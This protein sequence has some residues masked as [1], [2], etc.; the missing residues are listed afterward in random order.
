LSQGKTIGLFQLGGSGMTRYLKELAPTNIFDIMAMVALYRPGPI[1]SIP[2]Y[3]RR[4]HNPKLIHYTDPKMKEIL[5]MSNGIITYQDDVLLIAIN[6]AGYTWEEADKLRKAMGKKIPKEMAAQ[7]EKFLEGCSKNSGYVKEAAL[8]LWTLIEPFAAYGFNKSHAASYA[9]VAYQT[10]FMKANFPVEFMAAVL[11]AE[12]GDAETIADVVEECKSMGIEI[13]PPSANDSLSNFTVIDDQH[14]R[15]GLNAIK[16]LGSDT[17]A[18]IIAQRKTGGKFQNLEDFITRTQTRNFNKKS[19]E[20]LVKSGAMDSFGER[21]KLLANTEVVLEFA[22]SIHRDLTSSQVSLFGVNQIAQN[23]L[24]LREVEPATKK[25]LISWEK[26][27]LGLYVSAHPLDDYVGLLEKMAKP[28]KQVIEQKIPLATI[29]GIITKVQKILTKKGELMAFITVED[30]TNSIE[31]LVFPSLF[32]KV[33]DII[34]EEKIILI[35]GKLSSK[36]GELKLLADDIKEL[37]SPATSPTPTAPPAV[38]IKIPE[39]ATDEIFIELKR[40]FELSPGNLM[41]NL[42]IKDQKVKTPFLV[43]LT[44]DLKQKIKDLLGT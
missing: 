34:F 14:I 23:K 36:D 3:I 44:D 2:E 38:T 21:N 42:M 6:I 31:V 19:W 35:S 30:L 39:N 28:I 11:T 43:N 10:A 5:S 18:S 4:K 8:T 37:N 33:K 40:L 12:S 16:N 7:K 41:V 15:F 26:E 24:T 17:I 25:D 27:L 20:A 13:L 1:E 22:R 32:Q 9:I 29:G